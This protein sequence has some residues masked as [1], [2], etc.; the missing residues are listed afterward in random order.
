MLI[1]TFQ[2]FNLLCGLL[3]SDEK[4]PFNRSPLKLDQVLPC[5][6]L[7]DQIHTWMMENGLEL[8]D[9]TAD[10]CGG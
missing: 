1:K 9:M 2:L 8:P 7:Q 3:S 4:D 6:E 10:D 5:L